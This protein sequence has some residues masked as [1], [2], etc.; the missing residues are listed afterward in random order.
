MDIGATVLVGPV[1]DD[2]QWLHAKKPPSDAFLEHREKFTNFERHASASGLLTYAGF[3]T[4]TDDRHGVASGHRKE[5]E[6]VDEEEEAEA[7][8]KSHD[9]FVATTYREREAHS[10]TAAF[11][12]VGHSAVAATAAGVLPIGEMVVVA[13]TFVTLAFHCAEGEVTDNDDA[14]ESC[15]KRCRCCSLCGV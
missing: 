8:I 7:A 11:A 15:W 1:L 2:D 13:T 9:E 14:A 10:E 6:L 3:I 4:A 5:D 12:V